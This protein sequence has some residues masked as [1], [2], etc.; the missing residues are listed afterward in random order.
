MPDIVVH[1]AMGRKVLQGLPEEVRRRINMDIFRLAV[2]GSDPFLY[3]R[4]FALPFRHGINKRQGIMHR[5]RT[6][7][8]LL[9]LARRAQDDQVFSYLAGF[10]CHYALDSTAHPYI[11]KEKGG[12]GGG[13]HTFIEHWLDRVELARQGK[14]LKDRP[15]TRELFPPFYPESMQPVLD[16]TAREVYGWDDFY[17]T[18]RT[19]WKHTKPL[20]AIMEDPK[21]IWEKLFGWSEGV[22]GCVSYQS[23]RCRHE[24][25]SKFD[26]LVEKAVRDAQEFIC[27][28]AAFTEGKISE[29]ELKAV[30]GNRS[31]ILG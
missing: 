16:T 7:E 17:T 15:I 31:Y 1:N 4:W 8:Y 24:D 10:L 28:A 11:I 13:R 22:L 6:G 2:N 30:I 29:E 5:T 23:N 26:G 20:Y 14:R 12:V 3:Y 19:A 27:A 9:A 25:F 18:F 21:G